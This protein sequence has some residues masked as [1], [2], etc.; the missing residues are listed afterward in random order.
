MDFEKQVPEWNAQGTEPPASLKT[1]GFESGYKP[2][3]PYF[4]WFWNRVSACLSELQTKLKQVFAVSDG[5]TGKSSLT[6][7]SY[8]VGNGTNAVQEKTPEDVL[9][10]IGGAKKNEAIPTVSAVSSDGVNYTA[11]VPELTSLYNGLI[12][13]I[14]PN[15]ASTSST[16]K[17][18]VNDFGAVSV[19][20][21]L[22]FNNAAMDNP[23]LATY[24][25]E[26][27]PLT[28]QYDENYTTGGI[29]KTIGKQ[30]TSAQDL[31]GSVPVESGGTGATDAENARKNLGITPANIGAAA[32]SHNQASTT[33]TT[34]GSEGQ[35]LA[36][37]ADGTISPSTK[38][39]GKLGTGATYSLSGTTLTI[40]TL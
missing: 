2:P 33:I 22:S 9:A 31:Y 7:G 8:L 34:G 35:I 29:W 24:F 3:A 1:S 26:G 37:N 25:T 15:K 5:G 23:K 11:T 13:T 20:V 21:P 6:A 10:D 39:I 18:N 30:K 17:I 36:V 12:L 38:T 40:T 32:S 16:I 27:R 4:N 19:K 14:I 28:L